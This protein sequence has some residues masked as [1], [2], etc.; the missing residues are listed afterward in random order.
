MAEIVKYSTRLQLKYDTWANWTSTAGAAF[1]PLKGEVCICEIPADVA[2]TG[3]VLSG[4]AYLMK[5]GDGVTAFGSLPWLSASAADV[6]TWAKKSE[7]DFKAW[8]TSS[9]GPALA[10]SSEVSAISTNISNMDLTDPTA[11]G[12]ATSVITNIS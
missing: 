5:V 2:A 3:E 10:T 11:S 9:D 6:H 12:T 8:L 4:K 1:V 7:A